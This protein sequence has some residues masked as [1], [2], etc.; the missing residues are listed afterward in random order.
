MLIIRDMVLTGFIVSTLLFGAVSAQAP[1]VA[2]EITT[3]P[4]TTKVTEAPVPTREPKPTPTRSRGYAKTLVNRAQF[5]CLDNLWTRE[6]NW[7]HKA[8]NPH[9][10]AFGIP[11]ILRLT[12]KNPYKQIDRGIK[13]IKH[14]YGTPCNAWKFWQA[15]NWY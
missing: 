9:S 7:N 1:V 11:Q 13:Y 8:A 3:T 4:V 6:S 15:N 14:R 2:K 5:K 12:E 10:S